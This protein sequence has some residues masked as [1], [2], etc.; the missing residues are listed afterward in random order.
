MRYA[1]MIFE[2]DN[3][4]TPEVIQTM[5]KVHKSVEDIVTE[6]GGHTWKGVCLP[7]P[8]IRPPDITDFLFGRKRRRRRKR[9]SGGDDEE[10]EEEEED[11]EDYFYNDDFFEEEEDNDFGLFDANGLTDEAKVGFAEQFSVD[12]YPEPYCGI[13]TGMETACFEQT[14]LELWANDGSY[15]ADTDEAIDNLTTEDILDKI[16]NYNTSGVFLIKK[17][18]TELLSGLSYDTDGRITGA[19]AAVVRWF[20]QMNTTAAKIAPVKGRGEIIEQ[21]VFEFEGELITTL[22][23]QSY[24]PE[25]MNGYINVKRSFGDIGGKTIL[26][27]V[28]QLGIGYLIVFLFCMV[29]LGRFNCVEHRAYL[30]ICG[31]QG[32]Y[33]YQEQDIVYFVK[34]QVITHSLSFIMINRLTRTTFVLT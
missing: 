6:K 10:L 4:L 7:L 27:D 5:Y 26:D 13:V 2:A 22:L 8:I 18:F 23:N 3:I 21:K 34:L 12:Q 20:S 9:Q 32:T 31:I 24:Y 15:D 14:I 33:V 1:F 17:N 30:A 25:G 16:N 29:M 11:Y 28:A 19:K